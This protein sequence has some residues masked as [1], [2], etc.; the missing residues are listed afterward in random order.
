MQ[1]NSLSVSGHPQFIC[2]NAVHCVWYK[3]SMDTI[4]CNQGE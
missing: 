1:S 2:E 4:A 3:K